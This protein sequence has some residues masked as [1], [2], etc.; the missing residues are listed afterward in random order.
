VRRRFQLLLG[1]GDCG[2]RT[3]PGGEVRFFEDLYGRDAELEKRLAG[4]YP[5]R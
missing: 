1:F 4:G 2:H 5:D 3:M